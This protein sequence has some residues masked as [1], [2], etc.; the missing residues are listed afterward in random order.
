MR[1]LNRQ[2][3]ENRA[4][5]LNTA[6]KPQRHGL[7]HFHL[8]PEREYDTPLNM[9]LKQPIHDDPKRKQAVIIEMAA[10][11]IQAGANPHTISADGNTAIDVARVQGYS[12]L[13][14]DQTFP[15]PR[16]SWRSA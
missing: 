11:L 7:Q 2:T 13:L 8:G 12:H 10:R 16:F 14:N 6:F 5:W 9:V 4:S 15:Q 3:P 1:S